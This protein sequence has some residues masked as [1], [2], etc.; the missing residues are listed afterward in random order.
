MQICHPPAV[1]GGTISLT[2]RRPSGFQSTIPGLVV[3]D[4][5]ART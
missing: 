3:A 4:L 2:V 5:F 1:A